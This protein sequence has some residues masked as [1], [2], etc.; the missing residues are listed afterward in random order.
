VK[1]FKYKDGKG[2]R[3]Y[4]LGNEPL[5]HDRD[6]IQKVYDFI[7]D[8]APAMKAADPSIVIFVFDECDLFKEAHK[9]I[10]GGD[11]DVTGKDKNGNWMVDGITFHR[12]PGARARDRVVFNGPVGIRRQAGEL[13]AMMDFANQKNGRTGDA[14]LLWGLTE[15]NVTTNNPDREISGI[16]NTSFLGG[17]FIAEIYGIGMQYGAFT[18]APWCISETDQLKTDFGYLGLPADFLP[19]SSYYHTQMMAQNMKGEFLASSGNNSYVKTIASI[20]DDQICVMILNEDQYHDFDFDLFLGKAEDSG[21]ALIL[22]ANAGVEKVI[23]G[24]IPNQ[25]TMLY[26]LSKS[27]E[28]IR[29]Y[30]YGLKQNLK[31]LPPEVK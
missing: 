29:Q 1:A 7:V 9:R 25:T 18:M 3:Y 6:G 17:Q 2:I 28:I 26:V 10:L 22:Q 5:L 20:S 27:G 16:G 12:Y 31:Y 19:R 30:T 4:A 13:A 23:S 15:F 11:L 24:T 14:K 8:L 21:K